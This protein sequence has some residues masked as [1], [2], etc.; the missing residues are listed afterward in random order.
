MNAE[1][2]I[3]TAI[4][5]A[6][7]AITY[8][9]TTVF[10]SVLE[11]F[12]KLIVR[13]LQRKSRDFSNG[14][15]SLAKFYSV[16]E[17]I[18]EL[19]YVDRVLLFEGRNGGG[20]PKAGS[21]FTIRCIFG[22]A[23]GDKHPEEKYDA[24]FKVDSHYVS[25]L[26]DIIDKGVVTICTA[27]LPKGSMLHSFYHEEGVVYS[28]IFFIQLD[29]ASN[30]LTYASVASYSKPFDDIQANHISLLIQ[31]IRGLVA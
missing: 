27:D 11:E 14:L 2:Q 23:N 16:F 25:M 4:V 24:L 3:I 31:R 20:V 21:V 13:K 9:A 17:Q 12:G 26:R 22:W 18:R 28:Q 19:Q 5:T 6:T 29:D 7:L 8:T 30:S 10:R 15:E 1:A